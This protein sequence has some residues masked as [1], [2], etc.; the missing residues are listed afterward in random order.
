MPPETVT[1]PETLK[2]YRL[3][4]LTQDYPLELVTAPQL[5]AKEPLSYTDLGKIAYEINRANGFE[6]WKDTAVVSL[7]LVS[8]EILEFRTANSRAEELEELAD[9]FIRLVDLWQ[10]LELGDY[11]RN[12]ESRPLDSCYM[13]DEVATLIQ[14]DR[15]GE[16]LKSRLQYLLDCVIETG[17]DLGAGF[18]E[19]V[20]KKILYNASR[21][22]KHNRKY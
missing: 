10:C 5:R 3:Q 1:D 6:D 15:K 8:T 19:V 9:I 20:Q 14:L 2:Q 21:P 11:V 13:Y 18:G 17:E 22:I 16:P 7:A 12:A 4:K